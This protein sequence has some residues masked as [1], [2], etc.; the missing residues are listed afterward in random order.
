MVPFIQVKDYE[1]GNAELNGDDKEN[2][3]E[4][5]KVIRSTIVAIYIRVSISII[6][7]RNLNVP[8]EAGLKIDYLSFH[9]NAGKVH[10]Y[11]PAP[12]TDLHRVVI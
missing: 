7:Q 1:V 10:G 4:A 8:K 12:Q 6:L 9:T 3:D 5:F 2:F 11:T